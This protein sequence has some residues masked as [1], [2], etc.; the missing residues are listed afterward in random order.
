MLD[1]VGYYAWCGWLL[2]LMWWVIMLD[3]VVYYASYG[4]IFCVRWRIS[5]TVVVFFA[6]CGGYE[7][8][9]KSLDQAGKNHKINH[10]FILHFCIQ[11]A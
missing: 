8:K 5:T 7:I 3:V 2:C 10:S 1:V 4:G 9:Q 6:Y 11:M